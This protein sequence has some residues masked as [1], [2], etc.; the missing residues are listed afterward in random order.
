MPKK[1]K[2]QFFE[3]VSGKSLKGYA[4]LTEARALKEAQAHAREMGS[5]VIVYELVPRHQI[6][7]V[8][9]KTKVKKVGR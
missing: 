4:A 1:K 3:Y 2:V 7:Y 9:G 6:T 5:D 8:P